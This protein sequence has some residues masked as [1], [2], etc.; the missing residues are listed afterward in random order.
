MYMY[1]TIFL[2]LIFYNNFWCY[3]MLLHILPNDY[4]VRNPNVNC[5]ILGLGEKKNSFQNKLKAVYFSNN[6]PLK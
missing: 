4:K 2:I 5:N 1:K 3:E 6:K